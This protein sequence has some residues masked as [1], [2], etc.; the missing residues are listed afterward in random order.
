MLSNI[1]LHE[2]DRAMSGI[3][4]VSSVTRTTVS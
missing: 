3:G 2:L 1:V 4:G